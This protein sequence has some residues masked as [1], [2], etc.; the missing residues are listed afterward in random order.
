MV[1][2]IGALKRKTGFDGGFG[3]SL[4]VPKSVQDVIQIKSVFPD[5]IFM[6][7]KGCFS[8]TYRFTDVNYA[9]AGKEEK[10][11]YHALWGKIRT[12]G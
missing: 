1:D 3:G 2:L 11:S 9:V 12:E 6:T 7:G 4:S 5:G 10:E 8:K